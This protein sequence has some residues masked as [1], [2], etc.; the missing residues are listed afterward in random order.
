MTEETNGESACVVVTVSENRV[1]QVSAQHRNVHQIWTICKSVGVLRDRSLVNIKI[2]TK[3]L[4]S[5][6]KLTSKVTSDVNLSRTACAEL[7]EIHTS[8]RLTMQRLMYTVL[9]RTFL[10]RGDQ[11]ID[12]HG[13]F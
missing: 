9:Q 1:R 7:M 11:K 10:L 12:A 4:N 2:A 5:V 6:N 13:E 3:K 8:L